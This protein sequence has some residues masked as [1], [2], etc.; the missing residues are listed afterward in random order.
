VTEQ[1]PRFVEAAPARLGLENTARAASDVEKARAV[2][3]VPELAADDGRGV[4]AE[5]RVRERR[6]ALSM[7]EMSQSNRRKPNTRGQGEAR[8]VSL[9]EARLPEQQAGHREP[10]RQK[11]SGED[12]TTDTEFHEKNGRDALVTAMLNRNKGVDETPLG[13]CDMPRLVSRRTLSRL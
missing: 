3:I 10:R 7:D 11:I 2:D 5:V 9:W 13:T 6:G 12:K 1:T 8:D 4:R